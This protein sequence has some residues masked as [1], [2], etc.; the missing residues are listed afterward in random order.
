M[1]R[2]TKVKLSI[3][4]DFACAYVP[5]NQPT[6]SLPPSFARFESGIMPAFE[7]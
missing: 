5:A 4:P 3:Q 2:P 6:A 1:F 7:R